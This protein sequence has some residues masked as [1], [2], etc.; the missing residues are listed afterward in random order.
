MAE[1]VAFRQNALP[2]PIYGA[3]FT[4]VF[5]ILDA[6]GDPVSGASGLDSEVSLNGD[7]FADVTTNEATEIGSSGIYYLTV[8]AAQMTADIVAVRVQTSTSGAKTTILTLYPRKLVT[9]RTGTSASAGSATSTIVLDGSASAVDDFY[10]GMVCVAVI[11]GTTE[12]RVISDYTGSTQ[13]ATVVPDWNTAPDN[14]DTFTILLPEGWQLHQANTTAWNGT[15]VSSPATAGI[16]DVNVKNINNVAAATPGASGGL[17]ISGSNSG[18]TT[19]GAL[20]ITGAT[21]HTGNVSMAAG[22]NITQSSSNTSALVVTGNGTGH[23]AIITSG[24]GATGDSVR[25]VANST[26]GDGL[27]ILGKGSGY[28]VYVLA[29]VDGIG[30]TVSA[31]SG[32]NIGMQIAGAGSSPGI[33]ITG[34]STGNGID[35]STTSGIGINVATTSGIG[36]KVLSGDTTGVL[37]ASSDA[38]SFGLISNGVSHVILHTTI[39]SVVSQTDLRLDAGSP[40]DNAYIGCLVIIQSASDISQVAV[41]YCVDWAVGTS[42]L[43]LANDP[44]IFTMAAGDYVTILADRSLKPVTDNERLAVSS[45]LASADVQ[46]INTDGTAADN[47]AAFYDS[48]F[49][50]GTVDTVTDGS[51]FVAVNTGLNITADF[52]NG[53]V[54]AFTSG[55]LKGIARKVSDYGGA[56]YEFF[57]T[58]ATG[59]ADEPFANAIAPGDTFIIIGRIG[60]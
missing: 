54:L 50:R 32:G 20:T 6:D 2:Y 25:L 4:I 35:I 10:N 53:S 16:P 46:A 44:G 26:N 42:D 49:I 12:V 45:N 15:A 11:D 55:T 48:A 24:A 30:M 60:A 57:F 28:G 34:G 22:L 5:P 9:I 31:N 51:Q 23:G 21:T 17:L 36:V 18:T 1:V 19:L 27:H 52:Y 8:L 43:F 38:G 47:A 39:A 33:A 7:T 40:D 14:N 29:G 58:G 13:T 3:P 56:G 41:G 59:D 37:L